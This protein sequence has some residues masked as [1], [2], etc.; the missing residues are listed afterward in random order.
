[1]TAVRSEVSS[2]AAPLRGLAGLNELWVVSANTIS[3]PL[4]YTNY[5]RTLGKDALGNYL[6]VMTDVTLTPAM[7]NFLNMVNNDAPPPGEHANENYAR[8][9]M[10]LFT[11]GLWQLNDDGTQKLLSWDNIL[12]I[13]RMVLLP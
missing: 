7:G 9:I 11:I 6:N 8:E 2:S 5:L 4:G 10:Q 1:M 3:D 13:N 12:W